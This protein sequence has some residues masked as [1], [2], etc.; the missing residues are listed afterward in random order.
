MQDEKLKKGK[1]QKYVIQALVAGALVLSF[2]S[3]NHVHTYMVTHFK[4][5][6]PVKKPLGKTPPQPKP[7]TPK[8]PSS[9]LPLPET[10]PIASKKTEPP[11]VKPMSRL[12]LAKTKIDLNFIKEVEGSVLKGYVPLAATT[13]SGVTIGNGVDLGQMSSSE[14]AGLPISARLK[15]KLKPYIGLRQFNAKA[16]LKAHPLVINENEMTELNT[17][18]GN[19]ILQPLAATYR[20]ATGKSFTSLPA[21]AQTALFS[22]AYQYGPNFMHKASLKNLWH[23]FVTRNWVKASATL[24]SSKLYA[25][26]RQQEA[27]L[28]SEIA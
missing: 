19:K 4:R 1:Y 27:L 13:K 15:N 8:E 11:P 12:T 3:I 28:L 2:S 5:V 9:V 17:I 22:F 20:K 16:F 25:N 18:V 6:T 7:T 14:L 10:I 23:C 21:A 24:R 26:R